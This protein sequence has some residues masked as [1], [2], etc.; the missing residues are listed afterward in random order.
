MRSIK[1][2]DNC[3]NLVGKTQ[4]ERLKHLR[5]LNNWLKICKSFYDSSLKENSLPEKIYTFKSEN[6]GIQACAFYTVDVDSKEEDG[7]YKRFEYSGWRYKEMVFKDREEL[8][9][10]GFYPSR[11]N[12]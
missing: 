5:D 9:F 12:L 7:E 3:F 8:I 11:V 6:L 2:S 1:V 4:S 10:E